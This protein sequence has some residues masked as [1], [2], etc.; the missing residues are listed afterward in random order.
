MS[1]VQYLV[2]EIP[3]DEDPV[4]KID[5]AALRAWWVEQDEAGKDLYALLDEVK[6]SWPSGLS[7]DGWYIVVVGFAVSIIPHDI[8]MNGSFLL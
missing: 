2:D 4:S 7:K 1:V 3:R 5:I 8:D 6:A